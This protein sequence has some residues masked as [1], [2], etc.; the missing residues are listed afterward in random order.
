MGEKLRLFII[1]F[2]LFIASFLATIYFYNPLNIDS[3]NSSFNKETSFSIVTL[4][5]IDYGFVTREGPY[6]NPNSPKKIAIITGLHPLE[7]QAHKAFIK[8][9][10]AH[11]S[12]LKECYYV[13][14]VN[15]TLDAQNYDK[16]RNNGQKLAYQYVV[17]DIEK[18][19]FNL[20]IDVHNNRGNYQDKRFLSIPVNSTIAQ[21]TASQVVNQIQWLTIYNPPN[22]TSP[23]YVTIPLIKSGIPS[24]IYETYMYEPYSTTRSHADQFISVLDQIS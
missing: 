23:K 19:D 16:G 15:V 14:K 8:S 24:I 12:T 17:P 1:L 11:N 3:L 9:L 13:Y 4:G 5:A 10:K 20:V 21:N 18:Q 7:Y 2:L 22:P 6:G